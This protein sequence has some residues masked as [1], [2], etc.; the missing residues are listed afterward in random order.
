MNVSFLYVLPIS[1]IAGEEFAAGAVAGAIFGPSG[2][3][4]FR[5]LTIVSM[6]S[7]INAYHLMASRVL[8]R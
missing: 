6:L 7:A 4:V 8:F 1:E 2:E 5:I 3:S